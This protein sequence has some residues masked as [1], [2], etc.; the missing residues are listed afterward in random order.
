[1]KATHLYAYFIYLYRTTGSE[2]LM[3]LIYIIF[4]RTCYYFY[5]VPLCSK[6]KVNFICTRPLLIMNFVIIIT[7]VILLHEI[8]VRATKMLRI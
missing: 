5:A 7:R 2:E 1:M 4:L 6:F 3:S 8:R